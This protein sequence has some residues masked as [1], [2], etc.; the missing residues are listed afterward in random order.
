MQTI[1]LPQL[2]G[3]SGSSQLGLTYAVP[4]PYVKDMNSELQ[5]KSV[6]ITQDYAEGQGTTSAD[7]CYFALV[8]YEAFTYSAGFLDASTPYCCPQTPSTFCAQACNLVNA[9]IYGPNAPYTAPYSG[10][11]NIGGQ[12]N[13]MANSAPPTAQQCGNPLGTSMDSG[14]NYSRVF[15][16]VDGLGNLDMTQRSEAFLSSPKYPFDFFH[17]PRYAYSDGVNYFV[18]GDGG[19]EN[20]RRDFAGADL[21][22]SIDAENADIDIGN[23]RAMFLGPVGSATPHFYAISQKAAN[24]YGVI[25][26]GE[27]N[28]STGVLKT[29]YDWTS[30]KG[31]I[32]FGTKGGSKPVVN[33]SGGIVYS[34]NGN[35]PRTTPTGTANAQPKPYGIIVSQDLKSIWVADLSYGLMLFVD[36][37]CPTGSTCQGATNK[38]NYKLCFGPEM[39]PAT[40]GAA[41]PGT[42]GVYTLT[43]LGTATGSVTCGADANG[44]VVNG[45]PVVA[46]SN[47][48]GS[49]SVGSSI[50]PTVASI[51]Y[52]VDATQTTYASRWRI[53]TTA[54]TGP[55]SHGLSIAPAYKA[56]CNKIAGFTYPST[57]AGS[58]ATTGAVAASLAAAAA[59]AVVLA[60]VARE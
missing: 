3:A 19:I 8:G 43:A 51:V 54:T 28:P 45:V 15:V 24:V 1:A 37:G 53:L 23:F 18:A 12:C 38:Q 58:Q 36:I 29:P 60:A 20:F 5:A 49:Y 10:L 25:D 48:G 26:A 30:R 17:Q 40:A 33:D 35:Y 2:A 34:G 32:I 7:G 50:A 57:S 55:S 14:S 59:V 42:I 52:K 9:N 46:T 44:M 21:Y 22:P 39:G 13:N 47:Q 56:S 16:T 27:M 41:A 6:G 31:A 11:P 4:P